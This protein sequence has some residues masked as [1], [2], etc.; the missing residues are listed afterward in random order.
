MYAGWLTRLDLPVDAVD[1][2]LPTAISI[3][4]NPTFDGVDRRVEGYVIDRHDLDLYGERIAY[5]V[6]TRLRET[7]RF[8]GIDPLVVQMHADVARSREVLGI[9]QP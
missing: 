5:D 8:E 6:V 3:G 4:T 9:A 2:V 7:L 1:R